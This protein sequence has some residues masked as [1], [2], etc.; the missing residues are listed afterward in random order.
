MAL[1]LC[2]RPERMHDILAEGLAALDAVG[3]GPI[4]PRQTALRRGG[5]CRPGR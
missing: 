1:T 5:M 2:S 4:I 3:A